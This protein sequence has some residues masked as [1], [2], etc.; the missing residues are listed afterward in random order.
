[1]VFCRGGDPQPASQ[2]KAT[3][4]ITSNFFTGTSSIVAVFNGD[5]NYLGST[6]LP[7]MQ[8][9]NMPLASSSN[10]SVSGQAVTFSVSTFW[11]FDSGGI[12]TFYDGSTVLGVS[13]VGNSSSGGFATFSTTSLS[14]GNHSITAVYTPTPGLTVAT[15][16]VVVQNV[17]AH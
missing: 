14:V 6:S 5:D 17:S 10:P 2:G 4:A 16:Q 11:P 1:M 15:S 8:V 7:I 9:V 13:V 3:C 12:M